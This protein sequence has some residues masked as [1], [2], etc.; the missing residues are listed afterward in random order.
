MHRM[1]HHV[2]AHQ[3]GLRRLST[4]ALMAAAALA[5]TAAQAFADGE[6]ITMTQTDPSA[7][8]GYATSFNASGTLNPADTMFGFS[9]YVFMKDADRDPTCA[10]DFNTE[11]ATASSSGGN[12][13]WVS[14]GGSGFELGTGPTYSQPFKI[15]FGGAGNYLICGYVNSDFSTMAHGELRGVVRAAATTPTPAPNPNPSPNPNPA[16]APT[17][18]A[19]APGLVR[20]P[21]ITDKRHVLT[22]H[23]GSWSNAP[24]TERYAWYVSGHAKKVGS[25]TTLKVGS[26]V[27]N[28]KVV[29]KV[30]ASNAAGQRTASSKAVRA[31]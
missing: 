25:R 9:L 23:P 16:P 15:T 20:A 2:G 17:P 13:R 6:T 31:R 10:A 22:C 14:P 1:L 5:L 3:Q 12:E 24:T 26:A 21:W 7:V 19:K 8:V 4:L 28:R 29:C 30:T 27:R 11:S 18:T